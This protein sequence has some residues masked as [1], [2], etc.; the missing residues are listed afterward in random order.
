MAPDP[1]PRPRARTP[2]VLAVLLALACAATAAWLHP[3]LAP[4]G[5]EVPAARTVPAGPPEPAGATRPDPG[6]PRPAAA[7]V[8]AAVEHALTG[9]PAA[10]RSVLVADAL[11]GE[12]LAARDPDAALVPASTQKLVTLL[13]LLTH[14]GPG[15]RLRTRVLAGDAPGTVV[16]TGGGDVLLGAGSSDP[17]AVAGRAGLRTLAERTA[18]ALA[19]RGTTGP[20]T[21]RWDASL[22]PGPA[23]NPA[24]ADGDVAAGRIGPT[25]ALALAGDTLGEGAGAADPAAR[26]AAV[27]AAELDRLLPGGAALAP[28]PGPAPPGAAELAAVESAALAEQA[29]LMV[30]ESRNDLAEA[31]GRVAA[32]AAGLPG[33]IEGAR[34]AAE[35]ALAVHGI[36]AEGAVLSDASGMSL[37]DR[38]PA[39]TLEHLVRVLVTDTGGRLAPG[40]R[41]LPV[42]GATGTLAARFDDPGEQAGRGAAR[43]KTGTLFTVVSLSGHVSTRDGR[44]LTFAVLLDGVTDPAAARDA[45]DRAVAALADLCAAPCTAP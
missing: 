38:L 14:A 9:V 29:E 3:H 28:G 36:P 34:T 43:A 15:E 32:V 41:A 39:R 44:L 35:R 20:V 31:L 12:P 21:V 18:A 40:A 19:G 22:F 16:L 10:R 4:A 45:I 25:T 17:G 2:R 5:A 11:T 30:R 24:W 1:R 13:S 33:S 42:A 26:A 23:L 37:Q 8:T 6:A 7:D 27:L